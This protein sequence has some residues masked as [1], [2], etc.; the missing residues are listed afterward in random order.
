MGFVLLLRITLQYK[1]CELFILELTIHT[2][3]NKRRT[4]QK[5]DIAT[6][7]T[8]TDIFDFLVDEIKDDDALVAAG[9]V[10]ATISGVP[11][12]YPLIG[13]AG[14]GGMMIGRPAMDHGSGVYAQAWQLVW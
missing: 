8:R 4:L 11:Y 2:E 1:A 9:M 13:Q 6:A 7:I 5:N 12:F 10:G 3:E 14:G